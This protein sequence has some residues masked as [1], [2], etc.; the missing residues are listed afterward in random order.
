MSCHRDDA[1]TNV[2]S[3][4]YLGLSSE[5][6]SH[7]KAKK[8][9]VQ[10]GGSHVCI[11]CKLTSTRW[12]QTE[13]SPCRRFR[14]NKAP[15]KQKEAALK[16]YLD[17]AIE[18]GAIPRYTSHDRAIALGLDP[19][20]YGNSRPDWLWVLPDRW[21]VLECDESQHSGK[22]YSCER[23]RELQICNVAGGLPVHFIRINPDTFRTG[24]K[25]SR[26]KVAGEST[27]NRHAA[28]VDAIQDAVDEFNPT[29]LTFKKLF[30]D[31][32]CIGVGGKHPCNLIHTNYYADHENFLMS[33]Q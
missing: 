20:I 5:L 24:S 11:T 22:Q 29:G 16:K 17:T 18:N 12:K 21:I 14:D 25:S 19:I 32:E 13:C 27:A 2:E 31:C 4:I 1:T 8:F 33:F 30:F 23:R 28:V 26:V 15:L 3:N 10:C 9:C 6:C 7:A